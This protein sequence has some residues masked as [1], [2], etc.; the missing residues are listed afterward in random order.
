MAQISTPNGN[1][2]CT[3]T[4]GQQLVV[5]AAG[6][7]W[8]TVQINWWFKMAGD[9]EPWYTVGSAPALVNGRWQLDLTGNYL[10]ATTP[11]ASYVIIA[12]YTEDGQALVNPNDTAKAAM[13]RRNAVKVS[14]N[15]AGLRATLQSGLA[16][17][18]PPGTT[19][20]VFTP[21]QFG[22]AL[23]AA[24]ALLNGTGTDDTAALQAAIN[25]AKVAGGG[26]GVVRLSRKYKLTAA[27]SVPDSVSIEGVS[28]GH[29]YGAVS[30]NV[31]AVNVPV[32][33]PY[34]SG[35]GL[36]QTTAGA[37]ALTITACGVGVNLRNFGILFAD[38][39]RWTNTGH[40]VYCNPP[41]LSG[42]F[43]DSGLQGARWDHVSVYGHDGNHYAFWV[44]NPLNCQ[45][46][47]LTGFGGGGLYVNTNGQVGLNNYLG[48]VVF[49]APYMV[50]MVPGGAHAYQIDATNGETILLTFVRPQAWVKDLRGSGLVNVVPL[51]TQRTFNVVTPTT[52]QPFSAGSSWLTIVAPDLETTVPGVTY[53]IP[54]APGI[55]LGPG[56][57]NDYSSGT[58]TQ[59]QDVRLDTL[60]IL[61]GEMINY[62]IA[63]LRAKNAGAGVLNLLGAPNQVGELMTLR[64]SDATTGAGVTNSFSFFSFGGGYRA[65]GDAAFN[66]AVSGPGAEMGYSAAG[67]FGYVQGFNRTSN[68]Y[69]PLRVIGPTVTLG[70]STGL[71]FHVSE[72]GTCV[73]DGVLDLPQLGG[74]PPSPSG[75]SKFRFYG[76]PDGKI[77]V[78][79]AAGTDHALW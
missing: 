28:H 39:I 23:T 68:A 49:T 8:S 53:H 20:N 21:E 12:D 18:P 77:H 75:T 54:D 64:S 72:N 65:Q 59:V 19:A 61:N 76:N 47:H 30:G 79:D 55:Y 74:T 2:T 4:Q 29:L 78:V 31:E 34:F 58:N 46:D 6:V 57:L 67:G 15:F 37:N 16:T 11:T 52:Q 14:S 7:D 33:A 71:G 36:I 60:R 63:T 24:D 13:Q 45:M 32:R 25:V 51:G 40:G 26:M 27:L 56:L 69:V 5:A 43:Q 35:A 44:V 41:T 50:T 22:A 42:G 10:A 3:L 73:V 38:S 70:G 62:G 9:T 48:N 1:G 66:N 17:I